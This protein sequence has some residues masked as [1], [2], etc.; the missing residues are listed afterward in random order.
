MHLEQR[1]RGKD[2]PKL[3]V[4]PGRALIREGMLTVIRQK[5][6]S[7]FHITNSSTSNMNNDS[8]HMSG[9]WIEKKIYC[10]LFTDMIL[11]SKPVP[12]RKHILDQTMRYDFKKS[13]L[14]TNV[15]QVEDLG[16]LVTGY[17]SLT[18]ITEPLTTE[19]PA[20][21]MSFIDQT[22][23]SQSKPPA[24]SPSKSKVK[25]PP[26]PINLLGRF[27]QLSKFYEMELC[28][29]LVVLATPSSKSKKVN[30]KVDLPLC[31]DEAIV[32][33]S[34]SSDS[35]VASSDT[36]SS[37]NTETDNDNRSNGRNHPLKVYI[38]KLE[39]VNEKRSWLNSLNSAMTAFS[40]RSN[41]VTC[42]P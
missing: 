16:S 9:N 29:K 19:A 31:S 41:L 28:L 22:D 23:T 8:T 39:T 26:K 17:T 42:V 32:S 25:P 13:I 34:S 10:F 14:L 7:F 12:G 11:I 20:T 3:L 36:V 2:K 1:V 21:S 6:G 5:D 4:Q 35:N 37:L 18:N 24:L 40:S 27:V 15:V 30:L 33:Q 38:W